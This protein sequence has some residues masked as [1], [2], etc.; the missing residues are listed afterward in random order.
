MEIKVSILDYLGKIEEGIVVLVSFVYLGKY[1]EGMF[2][3]TSEQI[4]LTVD[5]SLEKVIESKIEDYK[6]YQ[7]ILRFLI[8]NVVPW[9]EMI[10]R[11]D[12]VDFSIFEP[13]T[14]ETV[15]LANIEPSEVITGTQ[16][17]L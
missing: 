2:I 7:D 9:S 13:K 1:Y 16:S 5:D 10:T 17:I 15:Y 3:Y 11:I 12:D 4:V 6:D 14:T 8:R